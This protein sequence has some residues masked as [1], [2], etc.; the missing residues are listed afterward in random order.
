LSDSHQKA[1]TQ[2]RFSLRP[3]LPLRLGVILL[4]KS[5]AESAGKSSR[6]SDTKKR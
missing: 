5:R 4:E 1:V 6:L 2:I 3:S